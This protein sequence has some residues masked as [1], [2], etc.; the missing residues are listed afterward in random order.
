MVA[1]PAEKPSISLKNKNKEEIINSGRDDA[2]ALTVGPLIPSPKF[3][4]K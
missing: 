1:K 3:L 4:V 2:I